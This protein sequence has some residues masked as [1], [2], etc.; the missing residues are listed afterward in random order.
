VSQTEGEGG[1]EVGILREIGPLMAR[2]RWLL[3]MVTL[4]VGLA[5]TAAATAFLANDGNIRR[6]DGLDGRAVAVT[7]ALESRVG[8][9]AEALFAIRSFFVVG[10]TVDRRDFKAF[11]Q[12]AGLAQRLPA[13]EVLEFARR[14]S[15]EDRAMFEESVRR[16]TSLNGV[17]YPS[18]TIYPESARSEY[19]AVDFVEAL[20]G[21]NAVFGLDLGSSSER[22]AAIE[23]AR[24][25]GELI[26]TPYVPSVGP[27]EE[28]EAQGFL[29]VLAVYDKEV[30]Q[31]IEERRDSV[32]GVLVATLD[33]NAILNV[34]PGYL[35]EEE[36]EIYDLQVAGDGTGTSG[37]LFDSDGRA[38]GSASGPVIQSTLEVGGLTL[39]VVVTEMTGSLPMMG[40]W[41]TW[42]VL[43]G[44][45][46]FSGAV[47][48]LEALMARSRS[49]A[50]AL[51]LRLSTE[52]SRR[53]AEVVLANEQLRAT[54][55]QL[56]VTGRRLL[57]SNR[58]LEEFASVA[59]HDLQEPLRKIQAFGDRLAASVGARLDEREQD[60]LSR[61]IGAA[62]RMRALVDSLLNY[63]R[64]TR[65]GNPF[66]PVDL[67]EIV[68]RALSDL[69]VM[70]ASSESRVERD[71]L[72]T[73]HGDP[74]QLHRLM[75]N[76]V[77]N[78]L[79]YRHPD[80]SPV[81]RIRGT[82][83]D[84]DQPE[85]ERRYEIAVEDN[86][87]GFEPEYADRIF[88]VFQ[89][90]HGRAE[91]EGT[92]IGLAICRRIV[93]RHGGEISAEGR[94]GEGATFTLRLPMNHAAGQEMGT[95]PEG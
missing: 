55:K 24:D 42:F 77:G 28:S 2:R 89:R 16:D 31:S 90:L 64:I 12:V 95:N 36:Y 19:W 93:E 59:A 88:G 70:T 48:L 79:K 21:N 32:V 60:Y 10:D 41:V 6:A 58:E 52:V 30:P 91:Y 11:V 39:G 23:R 62:T 78:A 4:G 74:E 18:F 3:P 82:Q 85:A 68:D 72:P 65:R 29:L 22:L 13:L 83:L 81:I 75:V 17:G 14:V 5:I 73:I 76:L 86:G 61:V 56:R 92:G 87:I 43:G 94:P 53:S 47:A 51:A 1:A 38:S 49:R 37:L 35:P 9:D 84:G 26:A 33:T 15:D 45:I 66:E 46:A 80:R 67:N 34:A 44:G 50:T 69:E 20:P 7:R 54:G 40:G 57:A 71:D 25:T 8:I 27:L 63:S